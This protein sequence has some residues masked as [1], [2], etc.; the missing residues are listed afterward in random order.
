MRADLATTITE[1]L[2]YLMETS[3]ANWR[4]SWVGN[5]LYRNAVSQKPYR[6]VN[7]LIVSLAGFK[8]PFM[9]TYKQ[10]TELGAQVRKGEK[11]TT[12]FFWKPLSVK[13]RESDEEKQIMMAR[14]YSVFSLDQVDNP[15]DLKIEQRPEIERHTECDRLL[16]D[17]GAVVSFGH[18]KAAYIPSQDRIIMPAA[19]QFES[20]DA[21]YATLSHEWVG[22]WTGA[23]HRLD[24]NL[25]GRFG[26]P[27]YRFE[28]LIAESASA[29]FCA[30]VGIIPEPRK[31]TAQYL[32]G[33]IRGMKDDK[34]AIVRAFSHAQRAVDFILKDDAA[35]APAPTRP[36]FSADQ[37]PPTREI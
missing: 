20:R 3:G 35:P 10:M 27:N 6:G 9:A 23:K 12:V 11:A 18:D 36:D 16:E 4:Q 17:S 22:H 5:G 25:K 26:D 37:P 1:K 13:D 33:W 2:I 21:F 34:Q 7:Q 28:E 14:T 8:S 29:F 24:R 19:N 32:N 15:P 31:E 30:A